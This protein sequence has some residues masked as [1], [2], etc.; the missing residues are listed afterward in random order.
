M[1]KLT[2]EDLEHWLNVENGGM[3]TQS[4]M[5]DLLALIEKS[6]E[7]LYE[8]GEIVDYWSEHSWEV[9]QMC[10]V[11][12]KVILGTQGSRIPANVRKHEIKERNKTR[13]ELVK[14]LTAMFPSGLLFDSLEDSTIY[15]LSKK[16]GLELTIK[17]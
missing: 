2:L 8:V 7:E 3:L 12:S 14:E 9:G 1:A 13:E 5:K 6:Y 11:P 15:D 17:E 16:W 10:A 4:D